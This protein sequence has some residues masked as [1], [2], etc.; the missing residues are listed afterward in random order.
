MEKKL[1]KYR[2]KEIRIRLILAKNE[3]MAEQSRSELQAKL[4]K[5]SEKL[6]RMEIKKE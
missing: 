6:A 2:D 1:K 5:T 4:D 3:N